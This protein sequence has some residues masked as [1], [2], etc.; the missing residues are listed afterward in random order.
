MSADGAA[1]CAL[2]RPFGAP[3]PAGRGREPERRESAEGGRYSHTPV[4]S[5]QLKL[6]AAP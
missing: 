5:S 2:T 4:A 3:S 1:N 6:A